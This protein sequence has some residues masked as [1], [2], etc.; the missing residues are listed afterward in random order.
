MLMLLWLHTSLSIVSIVPDSG[1]SLKPTCGLGTAKTALFPSQR[2][3][4]KLRFSLKEEKLLY[5]VNSVFLTTGS[6]QGLLLY[7]VEDDSSV[8]VKF[9]L[10]ATTKETGVHFSVIEALEYFLQ[11]L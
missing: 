6:G 10:L 11:V 3:R 1:S 5:T 9:L 8:V 4:R 2:E 7:S